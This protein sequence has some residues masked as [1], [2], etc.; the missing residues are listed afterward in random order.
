[1]SRLETLKANLETMSFDEKMD[2]LR[3]IR[4]NRK[5]SKHS[6]KTQTGIKKERTRK[7]V[8]KKVEAMSPEQKAALI[9]MLQEMDNA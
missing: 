1:M 8:V 6:L 3:E 4:T 5:V 2:L 7:S 9:K